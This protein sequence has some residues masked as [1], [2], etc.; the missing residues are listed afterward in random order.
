MG[1]TPEDVF[2][3]ADASPPSRRFIR[4]S[5]DPF[6]YLSPLLLRTTLDFQF[7]HHGAPPWRQIWP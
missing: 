2:A 6:L 5:N 4:H 3:L 7:A 1:R